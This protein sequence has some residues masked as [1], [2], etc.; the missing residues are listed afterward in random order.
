MDEPLETLLKRF[1]LTHGEI[2][3]Y[4]AL[5]KLKVGTKTPIVRSSNISPSKVYDVL[6]RLMKKGMA[7][8]FVENDVLHYV[9]VHPVNLAQVF[10]EKI[11]E[12]TRMKRQLE[13]SLFSLGAHEPFLPSVQLFRGW[14]GLRSVFNILLNDLKKGDTYYILGATGGEDTEKAYAFFPPVD[15]QFYKKNITRKA[16][17]RLETRKVSEQYFRQF[18]RKNWEARYFPTLGPFEIGIGTSCVAFNLMEKEPV[19]ILLNNSTIRNSFLG[20][21]E[22]LWALS[23]S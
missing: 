3:V 18:G 8:S 2:R 12:I 9:P 16:I 13:K 1:G 6:D 22:S 17:L 23:K 15:A 4:R 20:Y 21:F 5:L 7:T 10:D 19:S 11:E 14:K